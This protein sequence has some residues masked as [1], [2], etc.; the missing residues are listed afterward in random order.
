MMEDS[1]PLSVFEMSNR[2]RNFVL[3]AVIAEN[4]ALHRY[5]VGNVS[6][7]FS[8]FTDISGY[9]ALVLI[10]D[11]PKGKFLAETETEKYLLNTKRF[12]TFQQTL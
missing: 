9:S 12:L 7:V 6:K 2:L 10:R 5:V 3:V 1:D 4:P 8:T 11:A